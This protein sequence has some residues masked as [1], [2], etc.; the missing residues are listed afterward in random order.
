MEEVKVTPVTPVD[1]CSFVHTEIVHSPITCDIII[2]HPKETID[3]AKMK[4]VNGHRYPLLFLCANSPRTKTNVERYDS[5][6]KHAKLFMPH[7][8]IQANQFI[9]NCCYPRVIAFSIQSAFYEIQNKVSEWFVYSA[10]NFVKLSDK[11]SVLLFHITI[12]FFV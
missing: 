4:T 5:F 10:C 1:N 12:S 6:K 11:T 3:R 8:L 2:L 7:E 9:R